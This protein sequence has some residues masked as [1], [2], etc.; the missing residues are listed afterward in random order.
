MDATSLL[1]LQTGIIADGR[2]RQTLADPGEGLV[3]TRL[4]GGGR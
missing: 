1:A 2:H 3:A 4:F